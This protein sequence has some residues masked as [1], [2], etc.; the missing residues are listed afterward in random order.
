MPIWL[1][2]PPRLALGTVEQTHNTPLYTDIRQR[3]HQATHDLS[4]SPD[5]EEALS[6]VATTNRK[7]AIKVRRGRWQ[8]KFDVLCP[9]VVGASGL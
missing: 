6:F 2:P 5:T 4:F 8:H 9:L 1:F 3:L 7:A